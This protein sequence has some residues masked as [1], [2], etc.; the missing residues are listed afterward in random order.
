MFILSKVLWYVTD[1]LNVIL[2][3]FILGSLALLFRWRRIAI[4]LL[5]GGLVIFTVFGLTPF[6]VRTLEHLEDRFQRPEPSPETIAGIVV[7]GGTVNAVI[8]AA[9]GEASIGGAFERLISAADLADRYPAAPVIYTGGSGS[10]VDT[11]N[12]EADH[13]KRTF[14]RLG[15]AE[16]R[17]ILERNARNTAENASLS[18]DVATAIHPIDDPNNPWIL[19]TSARHMPRAMGAFR[20]QGWHVLAYPTDY[21][22]EGTGRTRFSPGIAAISSSRTVLY[23][24][25]GLTYYYVTGKTGTLYPGPETNP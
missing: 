18:I 20:K 2:S 22:T 16:S 6:G 5:S 25:L 23:E 24:M 15:L 4:V 1:P 17:L 9:R 7:L 3:A 14:E 11:D 10:I 13:V 19:V 12:R 21:A 8:S